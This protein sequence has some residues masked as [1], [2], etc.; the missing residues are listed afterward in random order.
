LKTTLILFI[1][2]F[3]G[4]CN[5]TEN[6]FSKLTEQEK[7][8]LRTQA[9]Q[10]CVTDSEKTFLSYQDSSDDQFNTS[11]SNRFFVN[12]TWLW[13]FAKAGTAIE[14]KKFTVWKVSTTAVYFIVTSTDASSNTTYQFLK[15]DAA[16]NMEMIQDLKAKKCSTATDFMTVTNSSSSATLRY[17]PAESNLNATQREKI[18]RTFQFPFSQLAFFG[19]L[20]ETSRVRQVIEISNNSITTTENFTG[21]LAAHA[22]EA[23]AYTTYGGYPSARTQFCTIKKNNDNSFTFP[24]DWMG[25][26]SASASTGP[27]GWTNPGSEL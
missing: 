2:S 22:D 8:Y 15:I 10:K 1:L 24:Y 14:T 5:K 20:N 6:G 25:N 16:L 27:D 13:T 21:T 9:S 12:K 11:S 19:V 17:E 7:E 26:C 3:I 18:V 4:A 23:P